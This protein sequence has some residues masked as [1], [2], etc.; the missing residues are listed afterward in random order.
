MILQKRSR[1]SIGSLRYI[2][3]NRFQDRLGPLAGRRR[4]RFSFFLDEPVSWAALTDSLSRWREAG[5]QD[6]Y[7]GLVAQLVR[8]RA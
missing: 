4:L 1:T 8:A 7:L 6:L 5:P 2:R 3:A